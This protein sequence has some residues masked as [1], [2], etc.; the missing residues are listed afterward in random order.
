MSELRA[1]PI[2]GQTWLICGGRNFMDWEMFDAAMSDL[3]RLRGGLP[4]TVIHGGAGGADTLAG[5]WGEKFALSVLVFPADWKAH[6]R[7]AGPIRN[8]EMIERKP[9][10]VVAFPGGRGTADM[11]RRARKAGVDVA[12]I[13]PNP[14]PMEE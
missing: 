3:L 6:G 14:T 4:E 11:V 7:A 9:D 1:I 2:N 8:Q 13:K 10:F 12:E 5:R